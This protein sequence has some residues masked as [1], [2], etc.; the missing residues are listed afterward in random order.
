M[1]RA[2][3]S[4]LPARKRRISRAA[5]AGHRAWPSRSSRY[6]GSPRARLLGEVASRRHP[7]E[8]ALANGHYRAGS[9]FAESVR[10]RPRAA[11]LAEPNQLS[12]VPGVARMRGE[13]G[14]HFWLEQGWFGPGPWSSSGPVRC[15]YWKRGGRR[16]DRR[17]VSR[18]NLRGTQVLVSCLGVLRVQ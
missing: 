13:L 4:G 5:P 3:A 18:I 2:H 10:M 15:R 14:M 9:R 7:V 12:D 11:V 8:R 16:T 17:A 1:P 6:A